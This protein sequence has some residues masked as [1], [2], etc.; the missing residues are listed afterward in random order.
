MDSIQT[1]IIDILIVGGGYSAMPL[2]RELE[3]DGKDYLI[4]SEGKPIW[5]ELE[6]SNR[7]DFDLVSSLYSS[8]FSFE[9]VEMETPT[10]HKSLGVKGVGESGTIGA[11]PA[12]QNAVVDALSHLGVRHIDMP[13][14]PQ[15]VFDALHGRGGIT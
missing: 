3:K 7:L 11:T 12:V 10:P 9:L 8:V 4:V 5:S 2:I 14:S 6:A 13:L 15:A 1:P